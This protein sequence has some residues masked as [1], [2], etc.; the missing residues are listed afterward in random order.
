[1][2]TDA[3]PRQVATI[4]AP[5][6]ITRE[7]FGQNE[8]E[9]RAETAASA[10][11]ARE[12]AAIEARYVMASN[13]PRS[14][15]EVEMRLLKECERPGFAEVA[16]FIRPVGKE[17]NKQT[18]AWEDKFAEGFSIRFAEAAIR[19]FGNCYPE[20]AVAFENDDQRIVRV[21]V[22]DLEANVCY[23]SEIIIRKTVERRKPRDGE[24]IISERM[25]SEGGKVFLIE[26]SDDQV[27]VKQNALVSKTLRNAALRLI[28]GDILDSCLIQ[29]RKTLRGLSPEAAR[30]RLMV[31]F[32]LVGVTMGDLQT[33][34][35]HSLSNISDGELDELRK[36]YTA[37]RDNEVTWAEVLDAKQPKGSVDDAREVAIRKI[38]EANGYTPD[39]V[40]EVFEERDIP[41]ALKERFG[42]PKAQTEEQAQTEAPTTA[43]AEQAAAAPRPKFDFGKRK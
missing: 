18:G 40:R 27:M 35:G 25:N 30:D 15:A 11:A 9:V 20:A 6:V 26:A 16:R 2:S 10:N 36:V 12:R 42:E 19:C 7:G 37:L 14:M 22:T 28:P 39:Q 23:A 33:F 5:G 41:A 34:L 1:M 4:P 43:A 29:I 17:K 8:I 13:R 21:S 24:Q 32:D 38:A 31:A 3:A